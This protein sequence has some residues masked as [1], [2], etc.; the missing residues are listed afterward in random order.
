MA[1]PVPPGPSPATDETE[2]K[3]DGPPHASHPPDTQEGYDQPR[4]VRIGW[5]EPVHP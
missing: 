5:P 3:T 2:I 1:A 4:H